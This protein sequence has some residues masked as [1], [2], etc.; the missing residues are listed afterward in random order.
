MELLESMEDLN[1]LQ[2]F[3]LQIELERP[4]ELLEAIGNE[5]RCSSEL[6]VIFSFTS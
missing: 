2:M 4:G 5:G 3:E 6:G 1:G